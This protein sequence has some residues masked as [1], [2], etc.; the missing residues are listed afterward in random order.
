MPP[1]ATVANAIG[2]GR[3][4]GHSG[5]ATSPAIFR[6]GFPAER[7]VEQDQ[8]MISDV[9]R[10]QRA[11]DEAEL[12]A[13]T[14]ALNALLAEDFRSIGEQGHLLDRAGWIAKFAEFSYTSGRPTPTARLAGQPA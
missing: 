7:A 1:A 2:R 11:F 9:H 12:R 6:A 13:D 14:D 4:P 5:N 3:T 8:L 10:L